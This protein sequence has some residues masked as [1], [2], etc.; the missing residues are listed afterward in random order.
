MPHT[1]QAFDDAAEERLVPGVAEA[2]AVLGITRAGE[3]R[4]VEVALVGA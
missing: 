2:G 1:S 4:P 3:R